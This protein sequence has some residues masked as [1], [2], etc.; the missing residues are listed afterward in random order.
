MSSSIGRTIKLQSTCLAQLVELSK[1]KRY[2]IQGGEG[3]KV[4]VLVDIVYYIII[5]CLVVK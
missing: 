5:K 4:R 1:L 3:S 2:D